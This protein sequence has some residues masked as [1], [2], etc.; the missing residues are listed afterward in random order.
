MVVEMPAGLNSAVQI[1]C[2]GVLNTGL[3]AYDTY[4]ADPLLTGLGIGAIGLLH[5]KLNAALCFCVREGG[6]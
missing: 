5:L 3:D 1:P 2:H 6:F 4:R